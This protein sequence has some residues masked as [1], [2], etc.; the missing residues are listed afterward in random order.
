MLQKIDKRMFEYLSHL[1][2]GQVD[3]KELSWNDHLKLPSSDWKFPAELETYVLKCFFLNK[4][5]ITDKEVIDIGCE[6][7]NKILWEQ[8]L[9]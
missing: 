4:D 2:F 6:Y 3:H 5:I 8:N 1:K 7:G 9:K